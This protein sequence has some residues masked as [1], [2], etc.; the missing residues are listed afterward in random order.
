M[1]H[2]PGVAH[3]LAQEW[4]VWMCTLRPDGSPHVT[5]VWFAYQDETWWIGSDERS[6]KVRNVK[7]DSR[8]VL[9]LESG[10]APVVAEG[11]RS[12]AATFP[13]TWSRRSARSTAAGT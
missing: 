5:P 10:A 12:C 1:A 9:A 8:V 11:R 3:R 13:T 7:A 6:V 2:A 4:N